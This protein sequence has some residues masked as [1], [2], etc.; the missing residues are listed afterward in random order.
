MP[1]KQ[2]KRQE[3]SIQ[4][5]NQ[6][7]VIDNAENVAQLLELSNAVGASKTIVKAHLL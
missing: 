5:R 3:E 2:H 1:V 7:H 4:V 6:M